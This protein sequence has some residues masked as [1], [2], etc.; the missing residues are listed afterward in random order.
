MFT[1][2]PLSA[3][4]P[5]KRESPSLSVVTGEKVNFSPYEGDGAKGALF[6]YYSPALKKGFLSV[7]C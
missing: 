1:H 3:K 7:L 5:L 2:R 6:S 4:D